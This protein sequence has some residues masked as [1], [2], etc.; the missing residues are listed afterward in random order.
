MKITKG[1]EPVIKVVDFGVSMLLAGGMD[2]TPPDSQSPAS[3]KKEHDS[4]GLE[5]TLS[6]PGQ[7]PNVTPP[8]K[9]ALLQTARGIVPEAR[10]DTLTQTGVIMGTVKINR[11]GRRREVPCWQPSASV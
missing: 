1:G 4:I 6:E 11:S 10:T 7:P 2:G 3:D 5:T 9:E 8:D